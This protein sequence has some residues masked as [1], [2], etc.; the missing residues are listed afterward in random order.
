VKAPAFNYEC[1]RD[2]AHAVSLLAE[3]AGSA[4]PIAGGQ[5]LGPMLNLRLARP[6]LLVD[7]RG[8]SDLRGFVDEGDALVY[9]AAV[10]HAEI[11]DGA[12][13]DALGG[14]LAAAARRIAYRAVRNRG[15]LGGSLA[16]ADPAADW[17]TVLLAAGAEVVIRGP[18]GLR[19]QALAD[20]FSG[21]FSVSLG[22][23]E[24]LVGV[25]VPKRGAALRWGYH[26]ICV[27]A[28][29][30]ARAF[31]VA[32]ED[33]P[34]GQR[35]AVVGAIERVPL[36]LEGDDA[37][38]DDP[39]GAELLLAERLPSMA[40]VPRRLHAVALVRAVRALES[41]GAGG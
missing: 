27:K 13:P 32:M 28:G 36:V 37:A 26:K 1:A 16:H 10:T 24:L 34:S 29:E 17:P 12:V 7:V 8:C 30:F 40:A 14:R 33:G 39:R 11:E 35:R 2:A 4:R 9:G 21:P 18:G 41:N 25:R 22:S 6:E 20:F 3:A 23:D 5:S 15:T 19:A 31:A 38:I